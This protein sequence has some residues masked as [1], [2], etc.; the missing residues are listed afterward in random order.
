MFDPDS[1]ARPRVPLALVTAGRDKWLAPALHSGTILQACAPR[2]VLLADLPTAG[3]GALLSPPPPRQYLGEIAADLLGD[4]PEFDR[5][6]L[7]VVDRSIA[8]FFILHLLP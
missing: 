5:A 6:Q 7:Y 3:H 4:P 1:L 8:D 2:C